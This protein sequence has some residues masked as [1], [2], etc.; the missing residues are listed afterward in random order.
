MAL[1]QGQVGTKNINAQLAL[2]ADAATTTTALAAKQDKSTAALA[3]SALPSAAA[4]VGRVLFCSNGDAGAAC[5][6][7]SN[8]TA[9][10][11]LA[12][13]ATAAAS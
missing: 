2:K 13:G 9:W 10:K 12:L 4:N 11:V 7:I 8:G 1:K 5:A 6:V 3:V